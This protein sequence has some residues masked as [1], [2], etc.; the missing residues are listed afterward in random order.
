[1]NPARGP[2]IV[3][4]FVIGVLVA[5]S[6]LAG[7]PPVLTHQGRLLD[8]TDQP[9]N[10]TVTLIYS[11]FD[12]PA[13]GAPL[14]TE[15]HASVPVSDGLFTVELGAA[16]PLS[17]DLFSGGGG[18][19]GGALYLQVQVAGEP[20]MTPR[21]R[22]G[23]APFAVSSTRVIGDITTAPGLVVMGDTATA[24]YATFGEKVNAGLHAAGSALAS[25]ASLITNDCDDTDADFALRHSQG[26]TVGLV[27]IHSSS[28][29]S[30]LLLERT[31]GGALSS[32]HNVTVSSDRTR[33]HAVHYGSGSSFT[34]KD[35]DCD[36]ISSR[37]AI[38]TKGTSAKRT[39]AT[40]QA[41]VDGGSS[42]V[43]D[44]DSDGDGLADRAV[45]EECDDGNASIAIDESGVHVARVAADNDS[46]TLEL[47]GRRAGKA[48][49]K[50]IVLRT[51]P[52]SSRI[53]QIGDVD[54]DGS[55]DVAISQ[56]CLPTGSAVAIKTK[57]TGADKDRVMSVSSGTSPDTAGILLEADT[58]GDGVPDNEISSLCL[59]A[60]S[61]VAI[62]S[63]GTGADK[64]RVALLKTDSIA[65][66][67]SVE[68]D[69]DGDGN[70]DNFSIQVCNADSVY[71]EVSV[72]APQLD[73]TV[74]LMKAKEKA[75]RTKCSSN[76]RFESPSSSS[77][78]DDDCDGFS[79]SRAL[80]Y[81]SD[82]DRVP[83]ND[84][85]EV[86]LPT[87]SSMAIK[88]KGTGADNNRAASLSCVGDIDGDGT[89][90]RLVHVTADSTTAGIAI[91]EPGVHIASEA[92]KGWDGTVKGSTRIDENGESR[93]LFDS[94]GK[95]YL[96][97]S[98]GVGVEAPV[99][100]IDVAGGA[101]CDGSNWVNASDAN[102]KENFAAIDG[103]ELLAKIAALPISEWNYKTGTDRVKH[104][105]PTAQ[106]FQAT[107]G[108]G[109]DGKSIS[110]ID[111]SGIAL[112]AIKELSRRNADL[113]QQ[114]AEL[115][116][117]LEQLQL[118]VERLAVQ[119]TGRSAQGQ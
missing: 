86:C 27:T 26:A 16:V 108:V 92:R 68:A 55:P 17:T 79:A 102:L 44:V 118:L 50:N 3:C 7:S 1:M 39:M 104:I 37:L 42:V 49:Y 30:G 83:E 101:Y 94:D 98:L 84:I 46:S 54:G 97:N 93:V 59:P 69:L 67:S 66:A 38:K 10:G 111:P 22:L 18:G 80:F 56:A 107:F 14:W 5:G 47:S 36:G 60:S 11:I 119:N 43:C 32:S 106:D 70:P 52:D 117:R 35:E 45:R 31:D 57:G 58:D 76:L 116:I 77:G 63:K 82:G 19:G 71:H 115:A 28:D 21:I 53:T 95:G 24:Y 6:T 109:S 9:V 41:T 65:A 78:K 90:D 40:M 74:A 29:S 48:K 113:A 64:G 4:L 23:S 99:H 88:T 33:V 103:A 2:L 75:N 81:D 12:A 85:E 89:V 25:G 105:G 51:S 114:N 20:P 110:T 91:D 15:D 34:G 112:A 87:G 62:K 13:G 72:S 8:A 96:S 73:G 61:A 100:R